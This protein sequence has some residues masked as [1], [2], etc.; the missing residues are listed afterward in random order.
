MEMEIVSDDDACGA[1]NSH[2]TVRRIMSEGILQNDD[3][4]TEKFDPYRALERSQSDASLIQNFESGISSSVDTTDDETVRVRNVGH[5]VS[6]CSTVYYDLSKAVECEVSKTQKGRPRTPRALETI[7][8]DEELQIEKPVK[9]FSRSIS[10]ESSSSIY[11]DSGTT[12]TQKLCKEEKSYSFSSSSLS[13]TSV[14][15]TKGGQQEQIVTKSKTTL[16]STM[17]T[18]SQ[19]LRNKIHVL[20]IGSTPE[21]IAALREM[22][23]LIENA[24]STPVHGRDLAYGLC[25]IIRHEGALERI[26]SNCGSSNKD[27]LRASGRVL[28]QIM[29]TENR[30]AVAKIGLDTVV[31]M[32]YKTK[33]MCDMARTSTGILESLFKTSENTCGEVIKLGGLDVVLHWCRYTDRMTLRHCAFA[34]ANLALYGGPENQ[35]LMIKHKVAEWLFPL[36]FNDD[37]SI[38][39]YAC[40]AI[41]ALVSNKEIEAAVIKS[42]TMELVLP[43]IENHTPTEF[44]ESDQSHQHGC[45][46][47][48]MFPNSPD[49]RYLYSMTVG[50]A[51]ALKHNQ[52]VFWRCVM[53]I[54][55]TEYADRFEDCRVDGDLL[56]VISEY[57]LQDSIKMTPSITRKR[58]IRE[59]KQLKTT[60]DYSSCDNTRLN[61]WLREI[62]EEFSLYT[63]QMLHCGID[64]TVLP[65]VSEDELERE[66]C[67]TNSIHRRKIMDHIKMLTMPNSQFT[68][69]EEDPSDIRRVQKKIDV[70]ISYRRS[71]GSQLASLLKVH[72]QLRGFSVFLDIERLRAGKFDV[73]LLKSV[74]KARNFIL[75]LTPQAL[76]RC[77]GD[78]E[79]KD[80]VHREIAAALEHKCNIIPLMDNF[81]WPPC[82]K[83]PEDIRSVTCFNGVRWIH[84]YQDACVDKIERFLRGDVNV[85]RGQLQSLSNQGS[86]EDPVMAQFKWSSSSSSENDS[87]P[88]N[89]PS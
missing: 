46:F 57:D 59:L 38:R 84:D 15:F 1:N 33:N 56:L 71:N 81:D 36:A 43:F 67:I 85:K 37:D 83:L 45:F 60:A 41:S 80:W 53:S 29:T 26:V 61:D 75:V 12:F 5:K 24:W 18:F 25:D 7:P 13:S 21:Q 31:K 39:Y 6:E 79:R 65:T 28:E 88:K 48:F 63:Y 76:D 14:K 55:F 32:T 64:K 52:F 17:Q 87:P 89:S 22:L 74:Q 27:L 68:T 54:G 82:E 78:N 16:K 50:S 77:I 23:A 34:L 8:Q 35:E 4:D 69:I 66:C 49:S 70:F 42:G 62:S 72:L 58:F 40:L 9:N 30:E 73:G 47:S 10:S 11:E 51:K 19:E 20:H 2:N 44:A 3:G 86:F